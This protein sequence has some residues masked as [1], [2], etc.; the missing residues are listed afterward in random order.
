MP[1]NKPEAHKCIYCLPKFGNGNLY[2]NSFILLIV[3]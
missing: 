1:V 2:K 3:I